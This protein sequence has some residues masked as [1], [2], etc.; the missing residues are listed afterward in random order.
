M[1]HVEVKMDRSGR[2]DKFCPCCGFIKRNCTSKMAKQRLER[3]RSAPPGY[4]NIH[5]YLT[6]IQTTSNARQHRSYVYYLYF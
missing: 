2:T 6:K 4:K 3:M 1:H 5:G